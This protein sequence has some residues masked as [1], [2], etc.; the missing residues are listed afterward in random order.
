M[1]KKENSFFSLFRCVYSSSCAA[2]MRPS[3]FKIFAFC[4]FFDNVPTV[5]VPLTP[6]EIAINDVKLVNFEKFQ[7]LRTFLFF[8]KIYNDKKY[9]SSGTALCV[10]R[11]LPVL[12]STPRTGGSFL[13]V[14][15]SLLLWASIYPARKTPW[16]F[17]EK[18]RHEKF[19]FTRSPRG[20]CQ[21]Q[22]KNTTI[23]RLSHSLPWKK[24]YRETHTR[25]STK[26]KKKYTSMYI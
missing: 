2:R 26:K 22:K 19:K 24:P 4:Y 12:W 10:F 23:L 6:G 17:A 1:K 18:S 20:F 11:E 5:L 13:S 25:A 16:I 8:K 21:I 9:Y 15:L 14:S 3:A 7:R